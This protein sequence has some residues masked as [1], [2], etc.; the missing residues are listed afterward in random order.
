[1]AEGARQRSAAV[2][3]TLTGMQRAKAGHARPPINTSYLAPVPA[4]TGLE[5]LEDAAATTA[6]LFA[7][8]LMFGPVPGGY[9]T[10]VVSFADAAFGGRF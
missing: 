6:G 9:F 2:L 7:I 5:L 8:I 10:P 3:V 4:D 1:M